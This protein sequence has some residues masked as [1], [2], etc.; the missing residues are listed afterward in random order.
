MNNIREAVEPPSNAAIRA[1]N[2]EL[3]TLRALDQMQQKQDR[4][5]ALTEA[6]RRLANALKGTK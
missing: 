6:K 1:Y 5:A 3:E 2:L 4:A